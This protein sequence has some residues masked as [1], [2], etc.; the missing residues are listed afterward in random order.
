M[1]ASMKVTQAAMRGVHDFKQSA[2]YVEKLGTV[3]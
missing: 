3:A 1:A 2:F